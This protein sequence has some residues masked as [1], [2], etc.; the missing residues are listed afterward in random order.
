MLPR[1]ARAIHLGAM[2]RPARARPRIR[3]RAARGSTAKPRTPARRGAR[4]GRLALIA[5]LC[6]AAAAAAFW[7]TLPSVEPLRSAPPQTT[8]LQAARFAEAAA[9][10]RAARRIQRWV[11]IA[12]IS[13]YLREAVVNSEDA[14]FYD[15]DGFDSVETTAAMTQAWEQGRLGRGASTLTQQLAKNLWLGE[16]RS[17]LR[18]AREVVLAKRLE[19]LGKE[20]VLELYLNVVEWGDG[21]WGADAA[22]RTWF[23]KPS[24]QLLP[25][26]AAVLAAM[27]PA[28]RKRN[29]RHPSARLRAR[30]AQVLELFGMYRQLPPDELAA[31]RERLKALLG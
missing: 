28:P 19:G 24:S 5:L 25:E 11:P 27:L 6:C 13:N 21:V 12:S 15:H 3:S 4:W 30:A 20:R 14:R 18:K 8:A 7:L 10:G 31:A 22:A 26:E 16:E 9:R 2:P 17:L 23:G 29:P 1:P